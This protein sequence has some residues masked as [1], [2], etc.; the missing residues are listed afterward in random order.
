MIEKA[1]KVFKEKRESAI[2]FCEENFEKFSPIVK[3]KVVKAL[4]GENESIDGYQCVFCGRKF[5]AT[6]GLEV[7]LRIKHRIKGLQ[8]YWNLFRFNRRSF[9][10]YCKYC[11]KE[12]DNALRVF[13]GSRECRSKFTAEK[14]RREEGS[15]HSFIDRSREYVQ[16]IKGKTYEEIYGKTRGKEIRKKLSESH[17]GKSPTEE[18]RNK[19]SI[20]MKEKILNGEWSPNVANSFTHWKNELRI[21]GKVFKFRSSWEL[22]VFQQLKDIYPISEI[23]YETLRIPY[24]YNGVEHVY[25]V[26]FYVPFKR[27]AI[28]VKPRNSLLDE[29]EQEKMKICRKFCEQ[30]N[31]TFLIFDENKKSIV[32]EILDSLGLLEVKKEKVGEWGELICGSKQI[33]LL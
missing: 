21:E 7:H 20:T 9:K 8:A 29:Q 4:K 25:I 2:E 3:E 30:N 33:K 27:L 10:H 24:K 1:R 18:A 31:I 14:N 5:K 6:S 23:E 19:Q 17:K 15:G 13:C 26:D 11:G 22:E 12:L 16:S 28:E 32:R